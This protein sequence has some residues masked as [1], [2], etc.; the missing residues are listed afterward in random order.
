MRLLKGTPI[1]QSINE[2]DGVGILKG[3]VYSRSELAR[4]LGDFRD[5]ELSA[6]VLPWHAAG[7]LGKLVPEFLHLP[8]ERRLGW[9]LDAKG[10]R[11]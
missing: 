4:M 6:G 3:D 7:L 10:I 5:L 1:Q 2:V 11:P 9:F 8:L